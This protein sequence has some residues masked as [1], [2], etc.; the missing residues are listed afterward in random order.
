MVGS[1]TTLLFLLAGHVFAQQPTLVFNLSPG[2]VIAGTPA[3]CWLNAL[4]DSDQP[5]SWTFPLRV[6]CQLISTRA[7]NTA[8]FEWHGSAETNAVTLSPGAFAKRPYDLIIPATMTGQVI[9]EP[10]GVGANRLLVEAQAPPLEPSSTAS[11]PPLARL[12]KNVPSTTPG[13]PFDPVGF[14]KEHIFPYEPFYFVAGTESPNAKFQISFKYQLLNNEGPLVQR[15]PPLKGFAI[16]F[17]QTSLWDWNRASAPF[18]DS[19]YKPELLYSYERLLGG[20]STNWYRLDL[21]AGFQHESN[22]K[23]GEN[24]RSLNIAYLRPTL[25]LGSDENFLFT[26]IP[27]AWIY[28]GDLS[29]NPDLA[30][31][32]GY[33]D[34]RAIVGYK[35]LQLSALGKMGNAA[36][37]GNVQLDLTYPL[38]RLWGT[39]SVYLHAQYFNGYGESLLDYNE[40]SSGFRAGFSLYR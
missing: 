7:T 33:V 39:F 40:R 28:L 18:Y 3:T 6:E 8:A 30:H 23:D 34:L 4:N 31:Y 17:T 19:S 29:D 36:N 27:R 26:L 15:A 2:P 24:S 9:V 11:K 14:F 16:G 37:R 10:L 13:Q 21:Q 38:T 1:T 12:I 22:G 35:G 25:T 32:R 20:R 5:I